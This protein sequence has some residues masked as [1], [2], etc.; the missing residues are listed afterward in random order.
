MNQILMVCG[1]GM[2]SLFVG[3]TLWGI[4]DSFVTPDI[5]INE[6]VI[7]DVIETAEG[8]AYKMFSW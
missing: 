6:P 1:I 7:K 2:V 5:T 8:K 4:V 3:L